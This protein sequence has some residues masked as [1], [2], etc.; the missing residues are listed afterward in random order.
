MRTCFLAK[1]QCA[2]PKAVPNSEPRIHWRKRAKQ[3]G[4]CFATPTPYLLQNHLVRLRCIYS[5]KSEPIFKT[6]YHSVPRVLKHLCAVAQS[7]LKEKVRGKRWTAQILGNEP[8]K[9]KWTRFC[10]NYIAGGR[11][12]KTET[13]SFWNSAGLGLGFRPAGGCGRNAGRA[14]WILAGK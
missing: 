2:P 9:K 12:R 8:F 3:R 4:R 10:E 14:F 6:K 13:Y 5:T 7:F 11:I 1:K